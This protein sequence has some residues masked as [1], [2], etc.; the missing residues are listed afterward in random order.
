MKPSNT[1]SQNDYNS[2]YNLPLLRRK[3]SKQESLVDFVN[4]LVPVDGVSKQDQKIFDF[5]GQPVRGKKKQGLVKKRSL[6]LD[7]SEEEDHHF[8]STDKMPIEKQIE[9]SPDCVIKMNS[10]EYRQLPVID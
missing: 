5:M 1:L 2:T 6:L 4:K 10:I 7:D 3:T 8:S 9:M